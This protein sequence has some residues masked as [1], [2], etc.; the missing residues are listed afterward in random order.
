M[1]DGGQRE[2]QPVD[3]AV[4]MCRF[5]G[6]D[7]PSVPQIVVRLKTR[8]QGTGTSDDLLLEKPRV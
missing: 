6:L 8:R 2:G 3:S 1:F 7:P 5:D 4:Q